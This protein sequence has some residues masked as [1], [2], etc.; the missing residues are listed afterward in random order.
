MRKFRTLFFYDTINIFLSRWFW[1][2][3]IA[4]NGILYALRFFTN[5]PEQMFMSVLNSVLYFNL[6]SVLIFAPLAWQNSADFISLVLSQPVSR[7]SVFGARVLSFAVP[8]ILTTAVSLVVQMIYNLET[9]EVLRILIAQGI[10]QWIAICCGFLIAILIEDRMKA[11]AV[12]V[13]VAFLIGFALDALNLWIMIN[14]SA[15]P[16]EK[17]VLFL[18]LLNPLALLKYLNMVEQNSS[19]WIG[20]AGLMLTRAWKDGALQ[21]I[22]AIALLIWSVVPLVIAWQW[23]ERK[24]L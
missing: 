13:G 4:F 20:Y 12:A 7:R 6:A 5:R 11:I 2:Y 9:R 22:G 17:L 10:L 21:F 14:Y 19:L 3:I 16:L 24:D 18:S 1:F 23:F 15:Y 8:V